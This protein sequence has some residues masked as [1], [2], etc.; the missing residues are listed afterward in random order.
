[1]GRESP[2]TA[3]DTAI[4]AAQSLGK[5]DK[6]TLFVSQDKPVHGN[7]EFKILVHDSPYEGKSAMFRC[8]ILEDDIPSAYF[9][10]FDEAGGLVR[11]SFEYAYGITEPGAEY[12]ALGYDVLDTSGGGGFDS[13]IHTYGLGSETLNSNGV[14]DTVEAAVDLARYAGSELPDHGPF[15]VP[16]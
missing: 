2:Q 6:P 11:A 12:K 10:Y 9:E 4:A 16:C 7:T 14:L 8:A 3:Q 5:T 1:M 15:S 13:A